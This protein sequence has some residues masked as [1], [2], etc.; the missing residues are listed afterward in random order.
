MSDLSLHQKLIEI[1]KELKVPKDIYNSFGGFKYRNAEM[2]LEKVKPLCHQQGL[3]ITLNDTLNAVGE[4]LV[5][6][7]TA[8][9]SDGEQTITNQSFAVH[10]LEKKGMNLAQIS[11]ATTSYARKYALGGLFGLD[12]GND[13]DS[14]DPKRETRPKQAQP[15]RKPYSPPEITPREGKA[16][17][18]QRTLLSKLLTEDGSPEKNEQIEWLETHVGLDQA[19]GLTKDQAS[20]A[21]AQLM[22][23]RGKTRT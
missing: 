6:I 10:A 21:I 23:L 5:A 12:D 8:T 2:I 16:T 20:K 13:P 3:T 11:G 22:G 18:N 4:T 9:L 1:Q 7:T 15:I 14:H 17:P 19:V